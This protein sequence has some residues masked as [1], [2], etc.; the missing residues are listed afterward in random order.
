MCRAVRGEGEGGA[1]ELSFYLGDQWMV[2]PLLRQ[3]YRRWASWKKG[4]EPSR[5]GA[6]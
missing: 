2:V 3:E 5:E 1:K 6:K 4:V